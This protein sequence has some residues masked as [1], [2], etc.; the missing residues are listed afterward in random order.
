MLTCVEEEHELVHEAVHGRHRH[1][2]REHQEPH[3]PIEQV[4]QMQC[5]VSQNQTLIEDTGR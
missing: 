2:Q 4:E 5:T 1:L 3:E